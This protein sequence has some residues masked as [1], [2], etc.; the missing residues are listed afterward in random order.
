MQIVS[1]DNNW[2]DD[3]LYLD[4]TL[5]N[6][7]NYKCWYCYPG[8]NHGDIPFPDLELLKK[9]ILHL[10]QYYMANTNKKM[11]DISFTGGEPTH[12]PKLGEFIQFCRESFPCLISMTSNGS[13]S[14]SWWHKYGTYFDRIHMSCHHEYVKLDK[15]RDLCD[16]LY[17]NGVVISVSVMM[18]PL[19]W[20]KCI[21]TVEY[22]KQSKRQWTIRYVDIVDPKVSYTNEQLAILAKHRARR[23]NLFW[24][25]RHNKYYRSK[26]TAIDSNGKKHRFQEN[27]ILLNR[28]NNFSGWECSVG[29]NWIVIGLTGNLACTRGQ[30]LYGENI[31]YNIY[32]LDFINKFKPKIKSTTCT[33]IECVCG[34][35]TL[36]PKQ[37]SN[38][39]QKIIPIYAS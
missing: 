9:N 6:I 30:L 21:D 14:Q 37:K 10:V 28:L 5:G 32:D 11:F 26:V 36:M 1:I 8:S 27:E 18:D 25:W 2:P 29:V 38:N 15:Y 31:S 4:I 16:W 17:D 35:E 20:D 24:F 19:A 33:K 3:V 39:I 13:K 34:I 12:W 23:V 22:L 7:C